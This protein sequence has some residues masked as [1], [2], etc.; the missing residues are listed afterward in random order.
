MATMHTPTG[1]L[2]TARYYISTMA[3]PRKFGAE[4]RFDGCYSYFQ[5][6]GKSRHAAKICSASRKLVAARGHARH[7][8]TDFGL[9]I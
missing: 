4:R 2:P 7:L 3:M 5:A 8:Q 9:D 6:L 1:H